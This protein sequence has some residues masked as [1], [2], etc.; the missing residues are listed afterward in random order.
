MARCGWRALNEE[1][2][3]KLY[4]GGRAP[5]PRRVRVFLAEKGISVP[6]VPVDMGAMGHKGAEMTVRNPLQRLPVLELDDGTILTESIAICRYFEALHPEP[7]LFGKGALESAVIEMWQRR[8]E[9]NLL[10]PVAAVFR[11][12]HPAMLEW[13][14]PQV[15]EW[16]EANRSKVIDF[17]AILDRELAGREYAAGDKYCVADITGLVAVDF[18]KPAKL[19]VPEELTNVRRWH[20]AIAARSSAQ[21]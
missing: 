18:M 21:A 10:G 16:G 6:L 17:L 5:N 9:L 12:L 19:L 3:M 1:S 8:M 14:V 2:G 15:R 13:E 11:H 4:D 20:A 7:A